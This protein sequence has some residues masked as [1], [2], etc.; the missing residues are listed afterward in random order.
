MDSPIATPAP[1]AVITGANRGIG[2]WIAL[3]LAAAGH[4][5]VM[6]VRDPARGAAAQAWVAAHCPG[7]STELVVADLSTV[8]ATRAAGQAIAAA[9]PKLAVL[10]NNA[11]LFTAGREVTADGHER[12]LAVNYLAP[13]V[14]SAALEPALR[15]GAPSRLVNVGSTASDYATIDLDDLELR[16]GWRVMRAYG[17]SKLA[18]MMTTFERAR[19]MA[20]SGVAVNVVHPGLVATEIG[21][22]PGLFGLAWRALKPFS[23]SEHQGADTPL[24]LSVS[25]RVAGRTGLYWKKRAPARANRRALDRAACATLWA[26]TERLTHG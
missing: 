23:L 2:R 17:Q 15:A 5:V 16:Q 19:R 18:L 7:A 9:H 6:V 3:G 20:G 14:L 12:V 21:I 22:V 11:G 26:E 1:V 25:P 13:F 8:A 10:V 24:F 4:H